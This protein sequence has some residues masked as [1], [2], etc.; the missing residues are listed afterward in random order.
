MP[1]PIRITATAHT[2]GLKDAERILARNL[3]GGLEGLGKRL[4][5]SAQ[6]RMRRDLGGE[7]KSLTIQ[8]RGRGLDQQLLVFSTLVRAFV[9]A[10]GMRRGVFIPFGP[11]SRL[12]RWASRKLATG[13]LPEKKMM[14][15]GQRAVP[16]T[17]SHLTRR[18]RATRPSRVTQRAQVGTGVRRSKRDR[19]VARLAYLAAR[20][21]YERGIVGLAWNRKAL[22]ANKARIIL[23]VR[24]ALVRGVQEINRT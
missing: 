19:A 13:L 18:P 5:N 23:D 20:S 11:G 6:S 4:R 21:I 14:G 1:I 15:R 10:L 9:D 2:T 12:Y 7:R 3:R 16:R 24:N 17:V 22:E 8:V